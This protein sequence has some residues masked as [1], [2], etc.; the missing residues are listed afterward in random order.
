MSLAALYCGVQLGS[1]SADALQKVKNTSSEQETAYRKL[2]RR[3]SVGTNL[4]EVA[5]RIIPLALSA[6]P[7]LERLR[8]LDKKLDRSKLVAISDSD[9]IRFRTAMLHK[10][11]ADEGG[12]DG[13]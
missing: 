10:H 4:N 7:I 5:S 8:Q 12:F 13:E 9:I 1:F 2:S 11:T 6:A 3:K